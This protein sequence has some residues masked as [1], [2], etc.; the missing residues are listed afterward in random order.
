[1]TRFAPAEQWSALR[2]THAMD[3]LARLPIACLLFSGWI[4]RHRQPSSTTCEANRVLRAVNASRRLRLTNESAGINDSHPTPNGSRQMR[5][6]LHQGANAT[7]KATGS[8][9]ALVYRRLAPRLDTRRP[10]DDRP[11]DRSSDLK[12]VLVAECP[13]FLRRF[14]SVMA[15]PN[16]SPWVSRTTPNLLADHCS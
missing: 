12:D 10:P 13:S 14:W 16:R 1:M 11:P 6:V 9:F 3:L 7:G 4:N 8:I 2:H 15:T 5:R